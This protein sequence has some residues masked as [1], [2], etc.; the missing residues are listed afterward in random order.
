MGFLKVF[1][2]VLPVV[3][4]L[5]A[6]A[7]PALAQGPDDSELLRNQACRV[8]PH[9]EECICREVHAYSMVPLFV[10]YTSS[11]GVPVAFAYDCA[12]KDGRRECTDPKD[13]RAAPVFDPDSLTWSGGATRDY[14][15]V[16][17]TKYKAYCSLA[18][19][20]ENLRRLWVFALAF[21]GGLMAITVAWCGATYMQEAV[22]GENRAMART[23][24]IRSVLGVVVLA[25]VFLIWEGVSGLFLQGF[26]IWRTEP[27][28]LEMFSD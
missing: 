19:F 20:R 4:V 2:A 8:N 24:L 27:G 28:F 10:D 12:I 25:A 15:V 21:A 13:K 7:G 6:S 18:Y 26:D 23:V 17:N 5:L 16:Q 22:S 1:A 9:S 3:G 14:V 11:T